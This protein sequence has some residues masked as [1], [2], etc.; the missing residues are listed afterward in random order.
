MIG[1]IY[2]RIFGD[3]N[4]R[5]A[6]RAMRQFDQRSLNDLNISGRCFDEL[7]R[8]QGFASRA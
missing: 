3:Q 6:R 1:A 4:D 8:V 5:A 7:D 2:D